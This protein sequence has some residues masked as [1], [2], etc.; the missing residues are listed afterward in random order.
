MFDALDHIL[1]TR[2]KVRLLRCLFSLDRA[3][4]GREACRLAGISSIG[5]R[6]LDELVDVGIAS[7]TEGTAQ[8]WY[9]AQR[10]HPLAPSL[11]ALFR[12]E[13]AALDQFLALLREGFDRV[14]S[15]VAVYVI[16]SVARG[17]NRPE[18]DLDL[19]VILEGEGEAAQQVR[20]ALHAL[21]E[22]VAASNGVR[23][24]F[25]LL[26]APQL[27]ARYA[28]GDRFV[29]EAVHDARWIWGEGVVERLRREGEGW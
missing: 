13:A 24:S 11:Q 22:E 14:D 3:V 2:N 21:G 23:A 16:G 4:S 20:Q 17:E 5:Q 26:G 8:H 10:G 27:N 28:T 25:T 7:R 9:S 1:G 15:I 6:A 19:L 18:S 29:Q 12:R